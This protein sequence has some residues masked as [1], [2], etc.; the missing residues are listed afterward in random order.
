MSLFNFAFGRSQPGREVTEDI[1]GDVE[2]GD[3]IKGFRSE[4]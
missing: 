3:P 4:I 2:M 1:F